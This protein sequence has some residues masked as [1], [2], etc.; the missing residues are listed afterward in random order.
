MRQVD[1]QML[2]RLAALSSPLPDPVRAAR[3]RAHC[4]AEL[5]RRRRRSERM[6]AFARLSRQVIAPAGVAAL[7]A[8]CL[9]DMIGIAVRT[10][11]A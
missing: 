11:T 10:L 3:V 4:C 1:E 9:A 2:E 8:A 5:A 6:T 7:C